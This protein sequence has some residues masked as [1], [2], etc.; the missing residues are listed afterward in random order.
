MTRQ[1]YEKIA[2]IFKKVPQ[3]YPYMDKQYL[4]Y[5]IEDFANM[6]YLENE[7]FDKDKFYEACGLKID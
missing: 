2:E 6:L 7:R 5:L 1:D 3:K 4:E